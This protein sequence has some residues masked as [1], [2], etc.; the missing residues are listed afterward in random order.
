MTPWSSWNWEFGA[1]RGPSIAVGIAPT[2]YLPRGP[3]FIP[4]AF[5]SSAP[6]RRGRKTPRYLRRRP[7]RVHSESHANSFG[8][9]P[10]MCAD[11][12][13]ALI[14]DGCYA[15]SSLH[16]GRISLCSCR[17]KF[18]CSSC[19]EVA[20]NASNARNLFG[21]EKCPALL[22]LHFLS[23]D[24]CASGRENYLLANCGTMFY[25]WWL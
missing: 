23:S 21:M 20:N 5:P 13:A 9:Y 14:R 12:D 19:R 24:R 7:C 11:T 25:L 4:A 16:R 22:R 10:A 2:R 17:E 15:R 3:L 1:N 6:L 8:H 18:T